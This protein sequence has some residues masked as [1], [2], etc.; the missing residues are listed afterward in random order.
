MVRDIPQVPRVPPTAV[1]RVDR[2]TRIEP[3]DFPPNNHMLAKHKAPRRR[4][5][6]TRLTVSNSASAR[7][8]RS[9]TRTMAKADSR[10]RMNTRSIKWMSQLTRATPE[11]RNKTMRS[12]NTA[13]VEQR[14]NSRHLKQTTTKLCNLEK[15]VHQAM[16]VMDEQTGRLLNYKQLMWDPK[17]KKDW[18]TSSANEFG[19]LANGVGGRIKIPQKK[20]GSSKERTFQDTE[21]R[22]LLMVPLCAMSAMKKLRKTGHV[23][24]LE[25]T[26]STILVR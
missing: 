19:R 1:P 8:T 20:S 4:H 11:K 21:E 5:A 26:G 16:V 10:S 23:S 6:Q 9:H 25:E 24:S 18:S 22:M 7:N 3:H 17:Y 12:E 14:R 15:E 13:A 2:T